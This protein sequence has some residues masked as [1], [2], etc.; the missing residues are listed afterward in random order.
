MQSLCG[1]ARLAFSICTAW[2]ICPTFNTF[3]TIYFW[4]VLSARHTPSRA[5]D[6]GLS[7]V[8]GGVDLRRSALSLPDAPEVC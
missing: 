3:L 2:R 6:G 5:R 8:G 4:Q 1:L 7:M